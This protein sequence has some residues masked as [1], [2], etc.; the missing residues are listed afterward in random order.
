M[1]LAWLLLPLIGILSWWLTTPSFFL[2]SSLLPSSLLPSSLLPSSSLPSLANKTVLITDASGG[3]GAELARQ[4]AAHHANLMLVT[5]TGRTESLTNRRTVYNKEGK[6]NSPQSQTQISA[7]TWNKLVA[8]REEALKLGS[9]KVEI[10]SFDYSNVEEVNTIVGAVVEKFGRLDYLVLN[11]EEV[12]RG[13]VVKTRHG[14]TPDFVSRTFGV[15]VYSSIELT[16]RSLPHLEKTQGHILL[17]SSLLA[18][19]AKPGLAVLSAT[20]HATHGFFYSLQRE[21]RER[22]SGVTLTVGQVGELEQSEKMSLFEVPSWTIGDR[23][24]CA[25]VIVE[26][27][28]KRPCSVRYPW[29]Q[30]PLVRLLGS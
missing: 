10:M 29:L 28:V 3:V 17:L 16:L 5:R 2:P 22:M 25:R 9:S 30:G 13:Y 1:R 6:S 20:Q 27:L 4:L 11:Q 12:A 19:V 7:Y 23:A 8:I 18:H 26:S 15:N 14:Q 21:L 24:E